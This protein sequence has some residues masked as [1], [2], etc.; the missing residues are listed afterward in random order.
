M[1]F[2]LAVSVLA[3]I[4]MNDFL[5]LEGKDKRPKYVNG[6]FYALVL[7]LTYFDVKRETYYL[8]TLLLPMLAVIYC[9]NNK[10]Y[11]ADDAFRLIGMAVLIG[12]VFNKVI[13]IRNE[14]IWLFIYF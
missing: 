4:G 10:K 7:L 2:R 12:T 14:N 8:L 9:N 5:D 11:N 1:W 6:I 13:L 3:V